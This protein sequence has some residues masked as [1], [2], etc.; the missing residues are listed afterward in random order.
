MTEER[1]LRS[2]ENL[3]RLAKLRLMDDDLMTRC[4]ESD[5]ACVEL[6]LR[7]VLDMPE[8]TV[9][10]V[11][12]QV[13]VSN[14]TERSLRMDVVAIDSAGRTINVEIQRSDRGAGR[15]RARFHSS[16]LDSVLLQKSEDFQALPETW[17]IFITERDVLGRGEALYKVERCILNTGE[18][19]DDGA[20]ILYVNGAFRDDSPLGWLM[21]DFSCT[22][23]ADMHYAVLAG[24]VRYFKETMEGSDTMCRVME[25]K[26]E[27]GRKEGRKEGRREGRKSTARK[28]LAMSKL[29]LEEI[30]E[31]ASLTLEEVRQ[32]AEELPQ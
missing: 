32:L 7:I 12:T 28:L 8:L 23:A 21:H 20:H 19:F 11:R 30:A 15:R 2:P 6:V 24:Q 17:V 18:L 9:R 22:R 31:C 27:E 3:A 10:S 4:F 5:P 16:M 26:W 25:E 13:P 1:S 29:T 14:L